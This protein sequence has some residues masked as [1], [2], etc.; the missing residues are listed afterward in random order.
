MKF[1]S[2]LPFNFARIFPIFWLAPRGVKAN[3]YSMPRA[4]G[5]NLRR[6]LGSRRL[7]GALGLLLT[8]AALAAAATA[9]VAPHGRAQPSQRGRSQ[10]LRASAEPEQKTKSLQQ[11]YKEAKA[12]EAA[13]EIE[14]ENTIDEVIPGLTQ[15]CHMLVIPDQKDALEKWILEE[16]E[17][18]KRTSDVEKLADLKEVLYGLE[19]WVAQ[20]SLTPERKQFTIRGRNKILH[21]DG[22]R[23]MDDAATQV[24]EIRYG[25]ELGAP[26]PEEGE[27]VPGLRIW[28][29][30]FELE[31]QLEAA[32]AWCEEMGA[33]LLTEVAESSEDLAEALNLPNKEVERRLAEDGMKVLLK[34]EGKGEYAAQPVVRAA[35][36]LQGSMF[37]K[38]PQKQAV[39]IPAG[40]ISPS[41]PTVTDADFES[42][43]DPFSGG[44]DRFSGL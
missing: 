30:E 42:F 18:A 1:G 9:F 8:A 40:Y 35:P 12:K 14:E 24:K 13:E 19:A 26:R 29:Q 38:K 41:K 3:L 22:I 15:L 23:A 25:N 16:R 43:A 34:L 6:P 39:Q 32:N 7:L 27:A 20:S 17:L 31:D 33:L 36:D 37:V 2:L 11:L 44:E 4:S 21:M 10:L 5:I 28:L